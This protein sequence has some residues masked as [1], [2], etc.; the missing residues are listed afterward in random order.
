MTLFDKI[1]ND[2]KVA[3]LSRE[4]AKLEALRSIKAAMLLAK[5]DGSDSGLTPEKELSIVQKLYK[6][7]KESAEIYIANNRK[8]LADKE[9]F[10]AEVIEQYL[11]K[12]PSEEEIT[13]ILT[14]I[15]VQTGAKSPAEMGKVMSIAA[16]RFAGAVSGKVIS[17]KVKQLLLNN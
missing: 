12:P 10:E 4:S 13:K 6:Q 8:E 3:M 17:E 15:I 16:K 5:T 9:F 2:I 14:E 11:P 7:R 1:S